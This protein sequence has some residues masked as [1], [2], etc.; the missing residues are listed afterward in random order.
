MKVIRHDVIQGTS[1]QFFF[2][3]CLYLIFVILEFSKRPNHSA[4]V[5]QRFSLRAVYFKF[6]RQKILPIYDVQRE[7]RM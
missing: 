5:S 2:A 3:K 4:K 7:I 1:S 6:L